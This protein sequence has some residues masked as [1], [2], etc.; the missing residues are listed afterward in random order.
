MM[1]MNMKAKNWLT[2]WFVLVILMFTAIGTCVYRV[3]P[4]FHYH[5]PDTS[6]YFYTIDNQRSQNDGIEKH[7]DY[8]AIITGSS[9]TQNFKSSEMDEIFGCNSIKVPFSGASFKEIN[10]N[11]ATALKANPKVTTVIRGLDVARLADSADSMRMDLG[12]YPTYLYDNNPFNDVNYLLNKDVVFG[13]VYPMVKGAAKGDEPGITSFDQYSRWQE[14]HTYGINSVKEASPDAFPEER[15]GEVAHLSEEEKET[16][17]ESITL[18]MTDLA[19]QHPEVTF[20]YFF[21]P[22]GAA[23]WRKQVYI[24][25]IEKRL[26]IIK[27]VAELLLPHENIRLYSY[28]DR[29][30]ITTDLNNY[31][32]QTHYAC[33]VNSLMLKW[34]HEDVGRLTLDNYEEVLTKDMEFYKSFD[35]EALES[36]DDYE[37]D[38][39]AGALLNQELTGAEPMDVLNSDK[40]SAEFSCATELQENGK[41]SAVSCVGR[42]DKEPGEDGLGA[43][44]LE[45]EYIGMKVVLSLEEGHNY[46]SFYGQKASESACGII[47][48]YGSEGQILD[49]INASSGEGDFDRHHYVVDLSAYEG[50]IT[51]LFNGGSPDN[52]GAEDAEYLFSDIVLY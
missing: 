31:R 9:M 8:D 35:Y 39:Y 4:F 28:T 19:D 22:Y 52:T 51:V 5:K 43:Y 30:D 24:G 44:L 23:S 18:N 37:A 29:Y 42:L 49:K 2:A 48:I 20:Y 36:Q 21:T 33:W 7:F 47:Y 50:D 10:D 3:D 41:V 1:R 17:K 38:N 15:T 6:K 14:N 32:D 27:Y 25:N 34:M 46:L 26:E 12:E 13:R 16:I 11:I 40:A 45:K